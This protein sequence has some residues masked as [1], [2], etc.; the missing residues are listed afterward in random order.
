MRLCFPH[1]I[2]VQWTIWLWLKAQSTDSKENNYVCQECKTLNLINWKS[3]A[4]KVYD[5]NR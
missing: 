3:M 2:S 1:T 4:D 5:I